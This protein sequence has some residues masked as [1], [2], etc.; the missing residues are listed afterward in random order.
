MKYIFSFS[1]S[2]FLLISVGCTN[3]VV[4]RNPDSMSARHIIVTIHG[5][6]GTD[7]SFG[8][9]HS[10][11]KEHLEKA[12]PYY[13]VIPINYTFKTGQ[14]DYNPSK[15]V[16]VN[17]GC[18][19]LNECIEKRVGELGPEDKISIV[20]YSMGGQVAME[21]FLNT[22]KDEKYSIYAERTKNLIG[23]GDVFWGSKH[24]Y[25]S[26]DFKVAKYSSAIDMSELEAKALS[27][28]SDISLDIRDKTQA[29]LNNDDLRR[30]FRPQ[31]LSIAGLYPCYG[32]DEKSGVG[33][34][35]AN[36]KF[37]QWGN[38]IYA[39]RMA[40]AGMIRR[41]T[42]MVVITP[43]A[44][45]DFN[46]P[47]APLSHDG[48]VLGL[49]QDVISTVFNTFSSY[50][51]NHEFV[52]VEAI[53][54]D[55]GTGIADVVIVPEKCRDPKQCD[56]GTYKYTFHTLA[57]CDSRVNTCDRSAYDN[58]IN[59]LSP[60]GWEKTQQ[61]Q[62]KIKS[63]L[64]GFN[65]ELKL[66]IAKDQKIPKLDDANLFKYLKFNF[67]NQDQMTKDPKWAA[68]Q[69]WF[70][71]DVDGLV[72]FGGPIQ[73]Q[74]G[75]AGEYRARA[76]HL[77]KMD[78]G[79]QQLRIMVTGRFYPGE[80]MNIFENPTDMKAFKERVSRGGVLPFSIEFPGL[81]TRKVEA[82]VRPG[83]STYLD[84]EMETLQ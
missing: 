71:E 1:F 18:N 77:V 26:T 44:N 17:M 12:D 24:A 65:I 69:S 47:P 79:S 3:L 15:S 78:D 22:M 8:A 37:T 73:F 28:L 39:T 45:L 82:I 11:V 36:S 9:F 68:V 21:W 30:R 19:S 52:A 55:P 67:Q 13:Q 7:K 80:G 46:A 4:K 57:G 63:D 66:R 83:M 54:A 29:W 62:A 25:I 5:V 27:I 41:E 75:R 81:K 23:L 72:P 6:R 56:H 10:I 74:V 48:K 49:K 64:Q 16:P 60:G 34:A 31:I 42:D 59:A 35:E 14:V 58:I 40:F 32:K 61:E 2:V 50:N 76:I 70:S 20:S 38:E 43:S 51:I 53:H 33:C 84:F